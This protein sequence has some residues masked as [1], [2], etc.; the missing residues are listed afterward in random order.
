MTSGTSSQWNVYWQEADVLRE[1]EVYDEGES[2]AAGDE[3]RERF[4]NAKLILLSR[5]LEQEVPDRLARLRLW[6]RILEAIYD[7]DVVIR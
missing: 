4:P 1:R 3:E 2:F 6:K 5:I 7:E